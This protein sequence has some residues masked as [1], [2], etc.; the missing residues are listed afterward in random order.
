MN[1]NKKTT[2]SPPPIF[3]RRGR[4]GPG[5]SSEKPKDFKGT[6]KKVID[7]LKPYKVAIFFVI[8]FSI[9]SAAFSIFGPKI[10]G[11]AT[12]K[13]FEGLVQKVSGSEESGIDFTA[14]GKT[15]LFLLGLYIMSS[16]FSFIQGFV[17]AGVTH[18][19]SFQLR[20]SISEKVNRIPLRFFD[21][22]SN[23][24]I[25]SRITNDVDTVSQT[26]S[27]VLS[28]AI[29]AVT[30]LIGIL[31]MM[32]S[33]SVPMTLVSLLVLPL[34]LFLLSFFVKMSQKHF[35][36]QQKYLGS[37]N[38]HIEEMYGGHNVMKAFNGEEKS[39]NEFEKINEKLY[40]SG[41]KSQFLSGMMMPIISFVS[42]VGYVT[43]AILGGWFAINGRIKVGDIL[44]FVQ[45]VRS[46]MQPISQAASITSSLQSTVAAAERV[47]EFLEEEEEE[48]EATKEFDINKIK[49]EV[50]FENVNFAYEPGKTIIH[51]FSM[52]VKPGQRIAIVGP[53]GAGKTTIV[54]LLMRFYDLE[55]G[56]IYID[57][58]N[59]KELK[60]TDLRNIFG[61]VLQDTWLF[62]GTIM[63]NIRYGNLSASD[64]DVIKAAKSA[65]VDHFV[66]SLP[67]G[68]DLVLNEEADNISQGQ[69]Q[70]LTIA[71]TILSDPKILILDEATSSVDTRTEVLIQKAMTKLMKN[72]TS[73]IIAHR[74]STIR[75]ADVILVMRDGNIVE[76]GNH[77][78]LYKANGFYRELYDSQFEG[79]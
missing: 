51:D 75:D 60:R 26:L 73:F 25:I 53:T 39:I 67:D 45:Y 43:I 28:E 65:Y 31:I 6:V 44:A 37:I 68:Y 3:G 8:L 24:D 55:S 62:N 70:L 34:S 32:F 52:K 13:L 72:R 74:L 21:R 16:L 23:G 4:I 36:D 63:E 79:E 64:E 38:G 30:M 10:L 19:V 71:R 42:N 9:G 50:T 58:H 54:K 18:K 56:N 57:N 35:D 2:Q 14:I 47:F 17:M 12:T 69:K 78:E 77:D 11:E 29:T 48:Q 7:Y 49:G 66:N 1:D 76:T 20:K 41:W 5:L 22:T 59:S 46:F 27:Q 61:M 40:V 33:I 15:L